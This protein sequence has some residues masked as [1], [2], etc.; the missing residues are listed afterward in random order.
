MLERI[1][2]DKTSQPCR[3]AFVGAGAMAREHIRAF[4]DVHG[5]TLAGI[6]NRTAEKGRALA[7]EFGL[8]VVAPN[9][10]ALYE[11]TKADIV[12][13]SV[14][15]TAIREVMQ[16]VLAYPWLVLMEKPIGLDTAEADAILAEAHRRGRRVFA[17]LNRRALSS[18]V[19]VLDDLAHDPGPRYIR[20]QDQQSLAVAQAIG[21][22]PAV[23][24][25][26][27]YANSIHLID[28]FSAF[29]RGR[30]V[31][32]A[33]VHPWN[34]EDPGI[35]IAKITFSSGDIGLYEAVWNGPGP[36]ACTITTPRRRW[37]LRP[38]ERASYVDA[39]SRAV[40][41]IEPDAWDADFKPGFRRQAGW[42]VAEWRGE[43]TP[44]PT[45]EDGVAAMHLTRAIYATGELR[46]QGG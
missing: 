4:G 33:R 11:E 28:Y 17:G 1:M 13:V 23:V 18:T 34:P 29:G 24:R 31:S 6:A 39:G 45:L 15:E 35:V 27:M 19:A 36:W 12:Q 21:H 7:A 26:W 38:L 37:E 40:V 5:V 3:V 44:L 42:T 22:D 14:Y 10:A 16:Q 20:V 43:K 2:S 25:G 8:P 30:V 41:P 46:E 9:V 32:V